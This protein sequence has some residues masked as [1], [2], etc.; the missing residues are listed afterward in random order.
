MNKLPTLSDN[1]KISVNRG[2][3]GLGTDK[4]KHGWNF[5]VGSNFVSALYKTQREAKAQL[6]R[7]LSTGDYDFYG[8]AE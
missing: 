3:L 7:Y 2:T 6:E 5:S 1:Q 8:T 4:E